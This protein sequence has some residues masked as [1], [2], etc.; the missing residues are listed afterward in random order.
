[1][2]IKLLGPRVSVDVSK[3]Q[4]IL[5]MCF[6]AT[7][8]CHDRFYAT[9]M[10]PRNIQMVV[11]LSFSVL[12]FVYSAQNASRME[13]VRI[14]LW[15]NALHRCRHKLQSSYRISLNRGR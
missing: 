14:V 15:R 2:H 4:N 6:A 7:S 3:H 5:S 12:Y 1:M 11:A 10:S 9:R 13:V 8:E